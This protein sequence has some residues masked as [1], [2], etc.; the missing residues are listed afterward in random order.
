MNAQLILDAIKGLTETLRRGAEGFITSHV[1]EVAG[2]NPEIIR[3]NLIT[4]H[5]RISAGGAVTQASNARLSADYNFE[6]T[7]ITAAF[8]APVGAITE[9]ADF[10]RFT[11]QLRESGR[12]YDVFDTGAINFGAIVSTAGPAQIVDFPRGMYLFRAGAEIQCTVAADSVGGSFSAVAK[13]IVV[14]LVGNYVR[15]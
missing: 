10:F 15:K 8:Q 6:L 7:G 2:L 3:V 1:R 9:Y 4:F 5:V 11:M 12:N 14:M 13:S